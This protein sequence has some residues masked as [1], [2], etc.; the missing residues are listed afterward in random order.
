MTALLNQPVGRTCRETQS[1]AA[2]GPQLDADHSPRDTHRRSVGVG[3]DQPAAARR[4]PLPTEAALLLVDP[5]LAILAESVDDLEGLRKATANRL[6]HLTGEGVDKDG[7]IRGLGMQ[8]DDPGV[9]EQQLLLD[10]I[11]HLEA[12]AIKSLEKAMRRHPLGPWAKQQKGLGD[13]Q[14]A[15]LLASVGD[16][17]WNFLHGRPRTVSELW[18]YCGLHTLPAGQLTPETHRAPAGGV[19]SPGGGNTDHH[20]RDTQGFA[21]RVAPARARGQKSNWNEIARMRVW[22]VAQSCIKQ[23]IGS[24]YRD[25]YVAGR[26]K[27]ADALHPVECRRCGPKGKPAPAGSPLSD[28]HKHA[29][30][31]RLIMKAV[32]K[33]LWVEARRIHTDNPPA[34]SGTIPTR[35]PPVGQDNPTASDDSFPMVEAPSG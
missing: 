2:G 15:R 28:G 16:P 6:R 27:Y 24:P 25:V 18:A 22:L 8:A 26:V 30:A 33:D 7:E 35:C 34:S 10:G 20:G 21:V 5:F 13:K 14:M 17:Y 19:S 29:R 4:V 32:L 11:A 1:S 3:S 23:P 31:T 12:D 9:V